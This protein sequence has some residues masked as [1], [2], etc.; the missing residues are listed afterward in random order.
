[1]KLELRENISHWCSHRELHHGHSE[2]TQH[3]IIAS[4][5]TLV[6]RGMRLARSARIDLLYKM[7]CVGVVSALASGC[8]TLELP[9]YTAKPINQYPNMQ[10]NDGLSIAIHSI[11]DK[12]ESK[13]YFG[14]DLLDSNILAL[15]VVAENRGGT[16]SFVMSKEGFT[17]GGRGTFGDGTDR[18][19]RVGAEGTGEA[20]AM[21]G[22]ILIAPLLI[23]TG[24]KMISDATIIKHNLTTIEL[25]KTTISPGG[26]AQG[27][28][29]FELPE[30]TAADAKPLSLLVEV[31]KL[32][33]RSVTRF[34][35]D[36]GITR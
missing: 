29:Y 35:F 6:H 26:G 33:D 7:A 4:C 11:V 19:E 12:T 23:F 14:I 31:M 28:V 3:D 1:M 15:L 22:A 30:S 2:A 27:F 24:A 36:V 5:T 17:L 8:S 25:R 18:D 34:E 21:T 20:I 9:E 10:T 32:Q 16:A 13:T